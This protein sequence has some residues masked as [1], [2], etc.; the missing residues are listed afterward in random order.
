SSWSGSDSGRSATA[1][2]CS[3][4]SESSCRSCGSSARSCVRQEWRPDAPMDARTVT[5]PA[6]TAG[7]TGNFAGAAAPANTARWRIAIAWALI[8][9]A[10]VVALGASLNVWVKRQALDTDNWVAT[11]SNMLEDDQIREALSVY[12]VNQLYA[13]GNVQAGLEQ[14]LPAQLDPLA[15]P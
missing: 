4:S 2:C 6:S 3:S 13:N 15:A 12:L 11:S 10:T 9:V 14:R 1:M 7:S 8:V 5:A